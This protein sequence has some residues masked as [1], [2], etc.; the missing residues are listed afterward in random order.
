MPLTILQ[1]KDILALDHVRMGIYGRN[2][3]ARAR[4]PLTLTENTLVISVD[5]ENVRPYMDKANIRVA[6]SAAG[7][8]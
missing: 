8:T 7:R 2:G 5:D 1:P 3:Q 4:S 6:R